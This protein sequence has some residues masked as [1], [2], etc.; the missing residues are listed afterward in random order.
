MQYIE[1]HESASR[2]LEKGQIKAF[3]CSHSHEHGRQIHVESDQG[4]DPEPLYIEFP[5][6]PTPQVPN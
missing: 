2:M 4:W 1:A 5:P 3:S 6:D